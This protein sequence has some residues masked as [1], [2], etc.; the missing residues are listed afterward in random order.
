MLAQLTTI[1]RKL[2]FVAVGVGLLVAF[3]TE[4]FADIP[5]G[6]AGRPKPP[7]ATQRLHYLLLVGAGIPG[8][9]WALVRTVRGRQRTPWE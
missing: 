4:A 5:V 2:S 1:F 3:N 7:L 8:V 9:L 6:R